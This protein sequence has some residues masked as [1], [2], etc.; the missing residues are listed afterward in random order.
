MSSSR[1]DFLA[2]DSRPYLGIPFRN[3]SLVDEILSSDI[4]SLDQNAI[5]DPNGT[6]RQIEVVCVDYDTALATGDSKGQCVL[7]FDAVLVAAHAKVDTASTSGTIQI[8]LTNANGND[9]LAG[10]IEI[11]AN[12]KASHLATYG[13]AINASY[14]SM[15]RYDL[16][17]I[18][19][20]SAG[21]GA[22]GFLI[23]TFYFV[24]SK[25]YFS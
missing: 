23:V 8:S 18:N 12:E 20:D 9:I 14:A 15:S 13:F 7:P 21:T 25:F 2:P 11:D 24:V 19:L 16:I 3:E 4:F 1:K 17:N 10:W 22:K 6:Y 5:S